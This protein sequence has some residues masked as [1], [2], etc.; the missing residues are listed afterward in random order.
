MVALVAL[1]QLVV[2]KGAEALTLA[3]AEPTQPGSGSGSG[4][5]PPLSCLF[6]L[7]LRRDG[8]A[9]LPPEGARMGQS[10]SGVPPLRSASDPQ[11]YV[12]SDFSGRGTTPAGTLRNAKCGAALKRS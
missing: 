2:G 5:P 9:T 11:R 12:I 4:V 1:D 8:A 7:T 3:P 10:G 6:L